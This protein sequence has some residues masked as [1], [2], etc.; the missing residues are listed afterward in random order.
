MPP[1]GAV[2]VFKSLQASTSY[3]TSVYSVTNLTFSSVYARKGGAFYFGVDT[4]VTS[5][6]ANTVALDSITIQD[7][8]SYEHGAISFAA[9]SQYVT[10]SNSKFVSNVGVN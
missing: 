3:T 8:V 1:T 4:Q 7:S 10:I 9:G 2:F 5:A 6:H